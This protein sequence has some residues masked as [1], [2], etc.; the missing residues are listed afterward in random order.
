MKLKVISS[1]LP[2]HFLLWGEAGRLLCYPPSIH[3][4]ID[5][6]LL[7]IVPR[8]KF[9]AVCQTGMMNGKDKVPCPQRAY[10]LICKT[11]IKCL[12]EN[13]V[14]H[15]CFFQQVLDRNTL[16]ALEYKKRTSPRRGNLTKTQST[17]KNWAGTENRKTVADRG[18]NGHLGLQMGERCDFE[19]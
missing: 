6:Y 12:W 13:Y 18:C 7:S 5:Q 2:L 8:A 1:F 11:G 4:P 19:R 14:K 3:L 17:N 10:R 16:P 9:C 15:A